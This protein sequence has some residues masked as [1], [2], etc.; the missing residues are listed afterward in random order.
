VSEEMERRH[1]A[2]ANRH[3]EEATRR[4]ARQELL[5]AK[6]E[7]NG[8]DATVAKEVTMAVLA[9][10]GLRFSRRAPCWRFGRRRRRAMSRQD[11]PVEDGL[12][13]NRFAV[14]CGSPGDYLVSVT[15]HATADSAGVG[16]W[17]TDDNEQ[18]H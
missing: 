15:W 4:I 10:G 6:L 12:I 11:T 3:I 5:I 2:Q 17:Y 13:G 1:L 7:R 14:S 8:R 9:M 16:A 18:T